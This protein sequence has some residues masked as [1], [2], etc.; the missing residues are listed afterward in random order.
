M[1]YKTIQETSFFNEKQEKQGKNRK[2]W[3]KNTK[4]NTKKQEKT[5]NYKKYRNETGQDFGKTRFQRD[6]ISTR[7][8]KM[9][10]TETRTNMFQPGRRPGTA[11][12]DERHV[13]QALWS[14][15]KPAAQAAGAD[16]SR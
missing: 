12:G 10:K 11:K 3:G 1:G 15:N 5:E 4:K 16:P 9:L 13:L 7:F 6:K 14:R 8:R 2:N